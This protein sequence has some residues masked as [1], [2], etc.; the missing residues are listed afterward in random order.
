MLEA[1]AAALRRKCDDQAHDLS[2]AR[3]TGASAAQG[4]DARI[5]L[6]RCRVARKQYVATVA[7][8]TV[9]VS[10]SPPRV[11]AATPRDAVAS[12]LRAAAAGAAGTRGSVALAAEGIDAKRRAGEQVLAADRLSG[13][14]CVA[15]SHATSLE[16][17]GEADGASIRGREPQAFRATLTAM[18]RD[19]AVESGDGALTAATAAEDA[20]SIALSI[21]NGRRSLKVEVAKP[22]DEVLPRAWMDYFG[23]GDASSALD[24]ELEAKARTRVGLVN[25][26]GS[27]VALVVEEGGRLATAKNTT[28]ASAS[29]EI[30]IDDDTVLRVE[31]ALLDAAR[32]EREKAKEHECERYAR[33]A[34][35]GEH[36]GRT[37]RVPAVM[38]LASEYK[39]RR[40]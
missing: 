31:A 18:L 12:A 34:L 14:G 32:A 16:I 35:G 29:L 9:D 6:R 11:T 40:P 37:F 39:P 23:S 3:E 4:S 2:Y 30:E 33:I 5:V 19:G 25:D 1:E 28:K 15:I 13:S 8:A 17:S 38:N 21:E 24:I 10:L 7:S 26:D 22:L 20:L 36:G 27:V